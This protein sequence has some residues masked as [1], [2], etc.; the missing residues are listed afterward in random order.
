M[1]AVTTAFVLLQACG[2]SPAKPGPGSP[3]ADD[4]PEPT[5]TVVTPTATPAPTPV[6]SASEAARLLDEGQYAEAAVS[7]VGLAANA[8]NAAAQADALIGLS[9]ARHELGEEAAALQALRDAGSLAPNGS[10]QQQ[11]AAYL[12][13]LRLNDAGGSP[14]GE[15]VLRTAIGAQLTSGPLWPYVNLEYARALS[16]AGSSDAEAAWQAVSLG[17]A[18]LDVRLVAWRARANIAQDDGDGPGYLNALRSLAA[19]SGAPGDLFELASVAL[20]QGEPSTAVASLRTVVNGSPGSRF[21]LLALPI[22]EELG[23]PASL[24]QQGYVYYRQGRLAQAQAVL[25]AAF[26]ARDG[27]SGP[28]AAFETFYLAA[29][30][31]DQGKLADAIAI[32]DLVPG[33]DPDS[34]YAHR[35]RYWAARSM[36]RA[37]DLTSASNRYADLAANGPR[38]EFSAEAGFRAGFALYR[39]R[40]NAGAVAAWSAPGVSQDARAFYWTGRALEEVGDAPAARAAYERA[41]A[42]ARLDFYA[43]EAERRLGRRP[44]LDVSYRSRSLDPEVDWAAVESWLAARVPGVRKEADASRVREFLAVGLRGRAS[45]AVLELAPEGADAWQVLA[46]LRAGKEAGV[47]DAPARLAVRLRLLARVESFDVPPDLLRVSYPLPYVALLEREARTNGLDPLFV[48]ALVR[49][50]SFW[51][52]A[53]HSPADAFGLTQVIPPTGEAIAAALN[54]PGFTTAD[55]LRPAVSL[56]FGAYYLAEQLKAFGSSQA[57]LSAYNGGP[58]NAARW[59]AAASGGSMADFVEAIDFA[60]TQLYV[61]LVMEHLA[62]YE[63]AYGG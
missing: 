42:T 43:M 20:S 17:N 44:A 5:A 25:E 27:A 60:E 54:V 4:S 59:V 36:E 3:S 22:L 56:R 46:A 10:I 50:E 58:H 32:Y 11:R 29:V 48:A 1:A 16:L 52:P 40:D 57:A 28:E 2:S 15:Q 61:I 34:V 55:L 49:Q 53:A 14:E 33:L 41:L 31:E 62:H 12:L 23:A 39:A 9:V 47:A 19:L 37:G 24:G 26:G 51:D 18:P 7:F 35:A 21:A 38:G 30:Y 63:A 8:P 13:G 6:T 45:A